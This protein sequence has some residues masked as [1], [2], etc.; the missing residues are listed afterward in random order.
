MPS[1]G[2]Q[3]PEFRAGQAVQSLSLPGRG[4]LLIPGQRFS[5]GFEPRTSFLRSCPQTL[6]PQWPVA[7]AGLER[8]PELRPERASQG[9][10]SGWDTPAPHTCCLSASPL[11]PGSARWLRHTGQPE[12]GV[13][14]A[15]RRGSWSRRQRGLAGRHC[16]RSNVGQWAL[17]MVPVTGPGLGRALRG[18]ALAGPVFPSPLTRALGAPPSAAG[19]SP[20][21]PACGALGCYHA[22]HRGGHVCI[23]LTPSLSARM[24][25]PWARVAVSW[26][27]P[28]STWAQ[29]TPVST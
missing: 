3:P 2:T 7:G 20:P 27:C 22:Q 19:P 4:G 23:L 14:P 29:W 24:S 25:V 13:E 28:K 26:L 6:H 12:R 10:P 9:P 18:H 16:G 8:V 17:G 1:A 11:L 21:L 15:G 5:K